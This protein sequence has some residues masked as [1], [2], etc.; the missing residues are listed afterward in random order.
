MKWLISALLL[1][2]AA[3][4]PKADLAPAPSRA[5]HMVEVYNASWDKIRVEVYCDRGT[6][7]HVFQHI[8]AFE[9][10][11]KPVR[12]TNCGELWFVVRPIAQPPYRTHSVHLTDGDHFITLRVENHGPLS[13][14][15]PR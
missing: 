3:C 5:D 14:V 4:G 11:R 6:R 15:L 12:L 10:V 2:A 13:S 7:R 9:T 8:V 1:F